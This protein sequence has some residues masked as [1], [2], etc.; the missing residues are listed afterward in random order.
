MIFPHLLTLR[1]QDKQRL[2]AAALGVHLPAIMPVIL[3]F[4]IILCSPEFLIVVIPG[5]DYQP[6]HPGLQLILEVTHLRI[7]LTS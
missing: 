1:P 5:G 2:L 7:I 3:V 4:A 6:R